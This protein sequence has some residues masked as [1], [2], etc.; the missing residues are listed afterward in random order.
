MR[1]GFAVFALGSALGG[2]CGYAVS[3][4][5][6][7]RAIAVGKVSEPAIDVDA[8]AMVNAAVR[9]AI[10]SNPST[11]LVSGGAADATLDIELVNSAAALAPLA[12]PN[13][14]AAQYRVVVLVKGRLHDRSGKVIW[15]SPVIVGEAPFLST[16]GQVE[17]LDGARR[18]ALSRAADVAAER[19]VASLTWH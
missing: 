4:G 2:A 8:A 16:P 17:A 15:E 7:A 9:H 13:L 5:A 1:C 14:R 6:G 12:D 10:A 18:R 11:R 19:L 3:P